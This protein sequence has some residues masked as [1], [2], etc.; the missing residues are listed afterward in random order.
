MMAMRG[1]ER[2]GNTMVVWDLHTR[3]RSRCSTSGR[4]ARDRCAWGRATT[5]ASPRR[6]YSKLWL[7]YDAGEKGW[8]RRKSPTSPMPARCRCRSTSPSPPTT[9]ACGQHLERR[10]D[11]TVRPVRPARSEADPR[12]EDRPQ[13][14]W[15]RRA[16]R[17]ARVLHVVAA[18]Q[19]GQEGKR[20]RPV[21]FFKLRWDGKRL[22]HRFTIDFLRR[23]SGLL[24]RCDRGLRSLC[25]GSSAGDGPA[26]RRGAMKRVERVGARTSG[27]SRS[28]RCGF[29]RVSW[30][31]TRMPAGRFRARICGSEFECHGRDL[32]AAALGEAADARVLDSNGSEVTLHDTSATA[33][34]F[35]LSSTRAAP[36]GDPARH[37]MRE[38]GTRKFSIGRSTRP[39][40]LVR[41]ASTRP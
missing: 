25:G 36:S 39:R 22:E 9:R 6:H 13:L 40:P 19:L 28:P 29:R 2:F 33:S 17:K 3:S 32:R 14:N 12:A 26:P 16:G 41:S 37:R 21:Q 34:Q 35:W 30:S 31:A 1:D 11:A 27:P 7:L 4:A 18:G 5:G 24:T 15:C 23:G 38:G 10:R 20:R 8:Q